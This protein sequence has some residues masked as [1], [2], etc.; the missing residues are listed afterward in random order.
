MTPF[1][2]G[3]TI[4]VS[5]L[6]TDILDA[7]ADPTTVQLRIEE[8]DG[9]VTTFTLAAATVTR[10]SLGNFHRDIAL[11]SSGTWRYEFLGAGAVAAMDDG[12]FKVAEKLIA[13]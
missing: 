12:T 4:R 8:P 10:A 1:D 6:F 7:A 2:I 11:D 13:A 5:V 9:T 3:D